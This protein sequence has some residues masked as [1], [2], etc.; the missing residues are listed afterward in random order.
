[1]S[2]KPLFWSPDNP[3]TKQKAKSRFFPSSSLYQSLSRFWR[4]RIRRL[5]GWLQLRSSGQAKL[6][7]FGQ[8]CYIPEG[9]TKQVLPKNDKVRSRLVE[10]KQKGFQA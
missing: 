8:K 6:D 1:M 2:G 10:D 4:S 5:I 9:K 7:A 3:L